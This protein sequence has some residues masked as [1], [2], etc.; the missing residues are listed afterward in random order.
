MTR[1]IA[2]AIPAYQAGRWVGRVA[3][4]TAGFI[5]DV[6]IVDDGSDDDTAAE[7]RAAGVEVVSIATNQGKGAAL[8][9]AFSILFERGFDAVLTL[10]ADGQHIADDIPR[11][12][13][14]WLA[15]A[16]LV[17]GSR[18]HLFADMCRLRRSSNRLSSSL[19]SVA[20]G[21]RIR[22]AQTGFRVYSSNLIQATGFPESRFD[23]E[24]AV[25]VRAARLGFKFASV[26][27]ELGFVDGRATSHYRPVVDSLRIARS[28]IR[29]RME[30][31]LGSR[32]IDLPVRP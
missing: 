6:L 20:A 27:I 12:V 10:D 17:L 2:A 18:E 4:A 7:A 21:Q 11:L 31:V 29:A 26:P 9:Q 1:R 28:V 3:R 19:I 22:D 24:S 13:A 14:R 15:G 30:F 25:V 23:A 32:K 5:P 16:D 8:R